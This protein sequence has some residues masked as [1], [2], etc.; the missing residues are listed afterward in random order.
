MNRIQMYNLHYI[1]RWGIDF[2]IVCWRGI[3]EWN[4]GDSNR[5]DLTTNARDTV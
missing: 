5:Y 2:R 4:A 3:M 1:D